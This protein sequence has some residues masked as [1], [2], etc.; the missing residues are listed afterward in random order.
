LFVDKSV[1][2][3]VFKNLIFL[4]KDPPPSLIPHTYSKKKR[5]REQQKKKAK[6]IY[7]RMIKKRL[8]EY[9]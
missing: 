2:W 8:F 9:H 1:F 7:S 5:D 6:D 3:L 4:R